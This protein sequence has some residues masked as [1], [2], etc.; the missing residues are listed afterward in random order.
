MKRLGSIAVL[1]VLAALAGCATTRADADRKVERAHDR[2]ARSYVIV[3]QRYLRDHG[4]TRIVVEVRQG[5]PDARADYTPPPTLPV[6]ADAGFDGEALTEIAPGTLGLVTP[7]TPCSCECKPRAVYDVAKDKDGHIVVLR[8]ESREHV[9]TVKLSGSCGG[10]CGVPTPPIPGSILVLPV[11]DPALVRIV[12]VAYDEYTVE[13]TCDH[14]VP[15][16]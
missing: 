2:T 15:A 10:G 7:A 13:V 4:L 8:L 5:D 16:P 6:P 1:V 12:D 3:K 14:P 9:E 11:G